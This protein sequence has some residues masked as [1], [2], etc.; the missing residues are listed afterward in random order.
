ML[1]QEQYDSLIQQCNSSHVVDSGLVRDLMESF[2]ELYR[3]HDEV[4]ERFQTGTEGLLYDDDGN[5][6]LEL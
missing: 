6:R 2:R 4:T 3:A 5:P 1:S